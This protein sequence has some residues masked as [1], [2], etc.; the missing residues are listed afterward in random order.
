MKSIIQQQIEYYQA[1]AEEYDEW[2]YRKGR[3]DRGED[4][5][6]KWF[7]EG[8]QV[9][10]ALLQIPPVEHILELAPGTGIWTQEL[11]NIGEKITAVDASSEMLAINQAKLQ[12]D[13]VTYIEADLFEWE[14]SQQFDMV[15]FSFWLSHVPPEKLDSFLSKV[16][17]LLK[18]NGYFF[19]LD[20]RRIHESTAVNHT[21][22]DTGTTLERIL[23][24]GQ[25]FNIVK[26]FY[27]IEPLTSALERANIIADVKFTDTFFVYA[28]GQKVD[29]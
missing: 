4:I 29:S 6:K 24:D 23:N 18:P 13:K 17:K 9:R 25:K 19:M 10:D 5:N 20:S 11:L 1:R 12:S 16:S 28:K 15:Y 14:T 22:P 7:A 2:W 27:E 21:I 8:Q 26:I 3:Y